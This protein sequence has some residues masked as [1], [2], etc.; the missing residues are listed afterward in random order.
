MRGEH[1]KLFR[2]GT[3][4]GSVTG[5]GS[6]DGVGVYNTWWVGCRKRNGKKNEEIPSYFKSRICTSTYISC[7]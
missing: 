4:K 1:V 2:M 3:R 5:G 6:M 7:S